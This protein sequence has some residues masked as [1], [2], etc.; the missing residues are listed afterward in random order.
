[1]D[2]CDIY[3][4]LIARR[5]KES[6]DQVYLQSVHLGEL[7]YG[8]LYDSALDWAGAYAALGV[9]AGDN[10]LA[11]TPVTLDYYRSWL[12]LALL[13]AVDVSINTDYRGDMLHY[14]LGNCRARVVLTASR[15]LDR[16]AEVLP[17]SSQ[18]EVLVVLDQ[19]G[20]FPD[21]PCRVLSLDEFRSLG[22]RLETFEPVQP[23]DTS[24]II[25]TSGTTG[26]SKGVVLPW[27]H[28]H[29]QARNFS[30][31]DDLGHDDAIYAPIVA[32]HL[33]SKVIP[34]LAALVNGRVVF[35]NRFSSAEFWVDIERYRCTTTTMV[36]AMIPWVTASARQQD[37]VENSLRYVIMAPVPPDVDVFK[38]RFGVGVGTAYS[39][40]EISNPIASDGWDCD[41]SNHASC[42]R[43]KPG[44][45][46][47]IVDEHDQEVPVGQVGELIVRSDEPWTL[48]LGYFGMPE[49]SFDA[50]RNG[51]FHTQDG[52]RRDAEGRFYF[53]DRLKD[54]IRRRGEN[55]S[56]FEVEGHVNQHPEVVESAAIAVPSEHTEDEV[57]VVVRRADGSALTA[58]EL[59]EWLAVRMPRFMVPRYVDFV[60]QLPKTPTD[61]LQKKAL[62][63]RGVTRTTWDREHAAPSPTAGS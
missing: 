46:V 3:P 16:W 55:I 49:A 50:W 57:M 37:A 33:G 1:M 4:H 26:P 27:G 31:I 7:T 12:A 2:E 9:Q 28:L 39:M 24:A 29:R 41:N 13:R 45:E 62:R 23:W 42:G 52:F 63:E 38:Q 5:A 17:R 25:Y 18:V 40:T 21:L 54:A 10:V 20:P 34:Y 61:R 47:R 14:V 43:L 60:E 58:A 53:V 11:M 48:N 19:D 6:P 35:R 8:D 15:F 32:Y 51:W 36:G 30:P 44:F 22:T 56:S 59:V